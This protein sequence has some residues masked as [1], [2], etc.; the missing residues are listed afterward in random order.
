MRFN[1][2]NALCLCGFIVSVLLLSCKTYIDPQT[3]P[4]MADFSDSSIKWEYLIVSGGADDFEGKFKF[5]DSTLIFKGKRIK[6][7]GTEKDKVI[8]YI[9]CL[10]YNKG[11][12]IHHIYQEHSIR[13]SDKEGNNKKWNFVA[14]TFCSM[15]NLIHAVVASTK[16]P[17]VLEG[18]AWRE[19]SVYKN[20]P[21][22]KAGQNEPL[23]DF[24]DEIGLKMA[25]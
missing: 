17:D 25:P 20:Y 4:I 2:K 9:D 18:E 15:P 21:L 6:I 13:M 24:G 12:P 22:F 11:F 5:E 19:S 14:R 3:P 7:T 10:Y 16:Y 23:I 1:K 8:E